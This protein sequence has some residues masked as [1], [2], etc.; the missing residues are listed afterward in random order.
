MSAFRVS[1]I[2]ILSVHL[3]VPLAA[4]GPVGTLNGTIP[5]PAG[6]V[7][8]GAT[9]TANNNATRVESR[10]TSTS[11]GTYTLPYLPAGTYTIRAN[12]PG[13]QVSAAENVIL[14][15]AQ[16]MTID[17]KLQVGTMTQEVVVS[18]RPEL[19][20]SDSAEIGQYITEQEYK[21]WPILVDDGQRQLQS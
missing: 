1:V 13:F 7:V 17:L 15:V 14:R 5:D 18:A 3:A 11:T 12:A 21:A 16:T 4:Q 20:E 8:P 2:L 10:T 19:L 6:A 9:V